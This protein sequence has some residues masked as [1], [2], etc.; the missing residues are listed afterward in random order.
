L[1]IP[2]PKPF[3][4]F[5]SF[6]KEWTSIVQW[7]ANGIIEAHDG[8][9][10]HTKER[11]STAKLLSLVCNHNHHF[12]KSKGKTLFCYVLFQSHNSPSENN[13]S[14]IEIPKE[15]NYNGLMHIPMA[16]VDVTEETQQAGPYCCTQLWQSIS[17]NRIKEHRS[18]FTSDRYYCVVDGFG[19]PILE[20]ILYC[21][22]CGSR[23]V[24]CL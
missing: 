24:G 2:L 18:S 5:A 4:K 8:R 19:F 23:L 11:T 15:I 12:Y 3:G 16:K 9:C 17:S 21:P 1:I 13:R 20:N 10:R 14:L 7:I 6:S 22:H